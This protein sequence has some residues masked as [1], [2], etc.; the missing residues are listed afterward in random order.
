VLL[1]SGSLFGGGCSE[2]VRTFANDPLENDVPI[3]NGEI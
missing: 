3:E 2:V 1:L